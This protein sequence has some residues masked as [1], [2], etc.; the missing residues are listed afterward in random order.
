MD[1]LPDFSP[2]QPAVWL[3]FMSLVAACTASAMWMAKRGVSHASQ[4]TR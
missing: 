3:G 2:S 4:E 1:F